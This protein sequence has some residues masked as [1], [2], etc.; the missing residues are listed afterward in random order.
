MVTHVI[1]GVQANAENPG[2]SLSISQFLLSPAAAG[3]EAGGCTL[4]R[5]AGAGLAG[6]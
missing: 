3:S 4:Y 2:P 1:P 5:G 6:R